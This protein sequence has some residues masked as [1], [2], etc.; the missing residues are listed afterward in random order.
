M[1]TNILHALKAQYYQAKPA[2]VKENPAFVV[3]SQIRYY[4][5]VFTFNYATNKSLV[6]G[7]SFS[8][9]YASQRSTPISRSHLISVLLF[10][11]YVAW[12]FCGGIS[13][14]DMSCAQAHW[15]GSKPIRRVMQLKLHKPTMA[16]G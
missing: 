10:V 5:P 1:K 11:F 6:P 15:V 9:N 14:F 2:N 13:R 7:L 12:C 3:Y 8:D 4:H 16:I